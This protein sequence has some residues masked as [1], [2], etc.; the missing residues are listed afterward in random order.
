MAENAGP[1]HIAFGPD[2]TQ[3]YVI[4]ELD[5]TITI[6]DIAADTGSMS[7]KKVVSTL[8]EGYDGPKP[9]E[10]YDAPS[11]SAEVM[12]SGDR[13]YAT[14]RGHDSIASF[15]LDGQLLGFTKSGGRLPWT[16][17]ED[18]GLFV[19]NNQ[20]NNA[21]RDPG[22]ISVFKMAAGGSKDQLELCGSVTLSKPMCTQHYPTGILLKSKTLMGWCHH[23]QG[24]LSVW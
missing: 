17:V 11:H 1:R 22:N 12:V 23:F 7:I 16:L 9:F 21:L 6:L 24:F 10:F 3:G 13:L 15:D 18:G 20:F 14:N 5:N 4:N 8:P 19:A 2:A